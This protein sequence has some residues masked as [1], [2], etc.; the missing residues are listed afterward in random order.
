MDWSESEIEMIVSD[1]FAML[2]LE[3]VGKSYNKT[4]HRRALN[5]MIPNRSQGSLEFKHQN[6]SAVLIK[7]GLPY[8]S[9]YKPRWKYQLALE[10][11]ILEHLHSQQ[12]ILQPKFVAFSELPIVNDVKHVDFGS[13]EEAP[14]EH[15]IFKEPEIK[16]ERK[17]FKINYIEKEQNNS[18]LGIQ[19]EKWRLSNEN[20]S[21]L[22]DKIEWVSK[23][24][25]GA[26]FDILSKNTNGTDRYIEVKTTKLGK[27]TPIF[28]SRNEYEVSVIKKHD[29]FLYRVFNY[30]KDPKLF[31]ISG[32]F[33][34]FCT[35]EAINFK[36]IF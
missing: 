30:N 8:I 9:G 7:L 28:F 10:T 35:K 26:G 11:G 19:F 5:G 1:Y 24:D 17:P 12:K 32:S 13:F 2:Q 14:P 25:D 33:D 23:Y 34:D 4:E 16:I 18:S 27:E 22:A 15:S 6:I 31:H 21:G 3:L 20:K 36:G 29:Y